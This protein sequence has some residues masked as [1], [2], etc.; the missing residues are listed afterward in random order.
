MCWKEQTLP[1]RG[2]VRGTDGR[3]IPPPWTDRPIHPLWLTE[4]HKE[5]LIIFKQAWEHG[6]TSFISSFTIK[7]ETCT[8]ETARPHR[9]A[10]L[11]HVEE[12]KIKH[13]KFRILIYSITWFYIQ[14]RILRLSVT[15]VSELV[16]WYSEPSQPLGII[17]GL[18]E[19]FIK[20]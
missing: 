15:I 7:Q 14:F 20:R 6:N 16:N 9:L 3:G 1:S 19:T 10:S 4:K 18:K 13:F 12:I 11:Q 17:S 8:A 5:S 2:C